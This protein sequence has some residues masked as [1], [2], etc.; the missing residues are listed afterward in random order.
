MLPCCVVIQS[1]CYF[2]ID[3]AEAS[4]DTG[5]PQSVGIKAERTVSGW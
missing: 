5:T 2:C 4:P 1:L 3:V